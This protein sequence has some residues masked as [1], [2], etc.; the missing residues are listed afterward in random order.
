MGME[1]IVPIPMCVTHSFGTLSKIETEVK[2]KLTHIEFQKRK[3]KRKKEE[4]TSK[5]SDAK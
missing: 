1:C 2:M 4:A 3:R 5:Q